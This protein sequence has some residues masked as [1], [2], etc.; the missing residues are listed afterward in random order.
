MLTHNQTLWL[1][2]MIFGLSAAV[3]GGVLLKQCLEGLAPGLRG[4]IDKYIYQ[5]TLRA[6]PMGIQKAIGKNKAVRNKDLADIYLQKIKQFVMSTGVPAAIYLPVALLLAAVGFFMGYFYLKNIVAAFA[7][8]LAAVYL[9]QQI[10]SSSKQRKIEKLQKQLAPVA[11]LFGAEFSSNPQV[12]RALETTARNAP[13]PVKSVLEQCIRDIKA[14]F[15]PDTAF[16]RLGK[17]LNYEY[18]AFFAQLL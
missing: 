8:V 13:Q 6:M 16:H 17:N 5:R 12:T 9:P 11:S 1:L 10:F 15:D 3:A 7:L 18:G 2:S 4:L 14:G